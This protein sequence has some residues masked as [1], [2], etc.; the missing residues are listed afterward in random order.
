MTPYSALF[1]DRDGTVIEDVGYP[2]DP[3]DVRLLPG[4][5]EALAR[6]RAG[7]IPII[8]ITNQSGVGRGLIEPA[9]FD[10]VQTEV[11]AR[12]REAG[13]APD[14]VYVCPHAPDAGCDCRKPA[15]GLFERAAREH[16]IDL[17]RAL[18]VGD[19]LRDVAAGV[20]RG[21]L[22]VVVA[23]G[24]PLPDELP[25][26]VVRA[27]D[28]ADA[29]ER[30]LSGPE[31][32][33]RMRV[34]V[35]ASGGGS[36]FQALID[37]FAEPATG[38]EM[39][40]LVASRETA[41]AIRRAEDAGI[42]WVVASAAGAEGGSGDEGAFLVAALERLEADLVVLAGYL[43]LVPP[44][45]VRGWWGRIINIHPALLPAFGGQGM[46]GARVHEAVVESGV[47]VTG[48]TVHFVDEA[49][50]R[51][52]IIAQWPVP[53]LEGDTPASVA[54]RVLAVEH[55]LLPDVV[56]AISEGAVSL[57]EGGRVRWRRPWIA[58][59]RFRADA[60]E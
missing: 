3:A 51:G 31:G 26:G 25:D 39:A 1:V 30:A 24:A 60:D 55:E 37:R 49:Y 44:E 7:G 4:A 35:F 32:E 34:V 45:V 36:N 2:S 10:A 42:P 11:V 58:G 13:A 5:A 53:V 6:I 54:G 14:A 41:G 15:A 47:R 9:A 8:M 20:A 16:G 18:Y 28:L 27:R 50:D 52:P 19:R 38:V 40:G 43:R 22:T 59:D 57:E 29:I 17:A 23:T 56:A 33:R 46:Y 48:A 12:L 21:G